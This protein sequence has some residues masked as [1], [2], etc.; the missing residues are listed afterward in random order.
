MI[1]YKYKTKLTYPAAHGYDWDNIPEIPPRVNVDIPE[2]IS[3]FPYDLSECLQQVQG[4]MGQ[5]GA[6]RT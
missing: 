4:L 2:I 1:W 5:S 6:V 3:I